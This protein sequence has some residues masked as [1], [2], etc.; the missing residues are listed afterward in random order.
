MK[1]LQDPT[2]IIVRDRVQEIVRDVYEGR[3]NSPEE[4]AIAWRVA[5]GEGNLEVIE[6]IKGEVIS[7][8]DRFELSSKFLTEG[9]ETELELEQEG[10]VLNPV[11]EDTKEYM[12]EG[13]LMGM[14]SLKIF[15][16]EEVVSRLN[17]IL[18]IVSRA[19]E[20]VGSGN[21]ASDNVDLGATYL[22]KSQVRKLCEEVNLISLFSFV[23]TLN[24]GVQDGISVY[25]TQKATLNAINAIC[26]V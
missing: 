2:Q 24:S 12:I 6:K 22:S 16:P 23:Y 1:G 5:E 9:K 14:R 10:V 25:E 7:S 13:L 4:R 26:I 15:R 21:Y 11:S 19:V 8:T 3:T 17:A 20:G 18:N